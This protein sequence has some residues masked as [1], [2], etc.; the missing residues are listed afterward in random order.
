MTRLIACDIDGTLLHGYG[1]QIDPEVFAQIE[2]LAALG[3]YFCPTSG[4]QYTSLRRL[5]APVAGSLYYICENGAVIFGPGSPGEVLCKEEMDRTLALELCHE[6]LAL[7]G[8][9]I[10]ISGQDRSYLCP[11]GGEIVTIMRDTVGNNVTILATPDEVPEPIVKLAVYAPAGAETVEPI[12]APRWSRHFRTAISGAAW[13][14]FNST[15]KGSGLRRLCEKL[16]VPLADVIAFGDSGNDVSMLE[17]AGTGYI[18]STAA[19]HLLERFP[20]RCKRVQD[21]LKEVGR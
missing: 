15:D 4:R 21:V 18:M 14:D 20:H 6:I 9:E 3:I 11:K 8:C 16:G 5:F 12:L 17:T 10:Q 19:P 13:L 2:R 1:A 7:P